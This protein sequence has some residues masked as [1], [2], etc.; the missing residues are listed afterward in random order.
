M[1]RKRRARS[2]CTR[3]ASP[4]TACVRAPRSRERVS[5]P[6]ITNH[7]IQSRGGITKPKT[8]YPNFVAKSTNFPFTRKPELSE[9]FIVRIAVN[10]A[11]KDTLAATSF[12]SLDKVGAYDSNCNRIIVKGV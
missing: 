5:G 9:T 2:A 1:G 12:Y 11:S 3:L 10:Y 4:R 8:C 7:A 6:D